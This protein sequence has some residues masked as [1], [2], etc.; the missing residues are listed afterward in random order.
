M[1]CG[2][3]GVAEPH[4]AKAV[5]ADSLIVTDSPYLSELGNEQQVQAE[6]LYSGKFRTAL[7]AS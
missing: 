3:V 7:R 4:P 6:S 2:S 1:P 5:L